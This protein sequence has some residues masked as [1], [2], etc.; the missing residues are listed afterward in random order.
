M[1]PGHSYL[2]ITPLGLA[3]TCARARIPE[4]RNPVLTNVA[5]H[6]KHDYGEAC[7]TSLV[8]APPYPVSGLA[9]NGGTVVSRPGC[10]PLSV[11][12]TV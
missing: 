5:K 7:T 8:V 6:P 1:A 2:C 10:T 3:K 9:I 4:Y 11:E 12:R